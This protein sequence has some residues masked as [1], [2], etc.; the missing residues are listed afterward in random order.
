M[1]YLV[2][3]ITAVVMS[4]ST[5]ASSIDFDYVELGYIQTDFDVSGFVKP[6]GII[7]QASKQFS[8]WYI[9]GSYSNQ[10][11]EMRDI[12]AYDDIIENITVDY[13]LSRFTLGG[14]YV[15]SIDDTT[16]LDFSAQVGQFKVEST[17]NQ[18]SDSDTTDV[19][20]THAQIRHLISDK[21]EVS[22]VVGFERFDDEE[23]ENNFVYGV[24][25]R[26]YFTDQFSIG[27]YYKDADEFNDISINARYNF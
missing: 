6:K 16:S 18:F 21:F 17:Y 9:T 22:A 24:G 27:A 15:Y 2:S 5:Y 12:F 11:D 23:S 4:F 20:L 3:S 10:E 26:Y 13:E 25:S 7:L 1:K 8:N 14:G 19:I